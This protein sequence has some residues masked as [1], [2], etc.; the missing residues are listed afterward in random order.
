LTFDR[1]WH[2]EDRDHLEEEGQEG[3]Q[4]LVEQQAALEEWLV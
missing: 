3:Q 2:L 1:K 4:V